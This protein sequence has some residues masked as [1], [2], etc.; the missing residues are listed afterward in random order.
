V[1]T[2]RKAFVVGDG[3]SAWAR[4]YND[5]ASQHIADL[6]G[7]DRL[8]QSQVSLVK[9]A[10]ALTCELEQQEGRLSLGEAIDL[11]S[12]GRGVSHLRRLLETLGLERAAKPVQSFADYAQQHGLKQIEATPE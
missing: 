10:A 5:L 9:R 8:S 4:R 12:Y 2:G 1:T 3:N 6:G 11:D 7:A